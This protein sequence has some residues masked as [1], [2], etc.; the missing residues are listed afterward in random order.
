MAYVLTT[1]SNFDDIADAIRSKN[2][3]SD[4]YRPGDMAEAIMRISGG[5]M[6]AYFDGDTLVMIGQAVT[7]SNDT[8]TITTD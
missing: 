4:T 6:T 8:I 1:E 2:G 7:V 5:N 3:S